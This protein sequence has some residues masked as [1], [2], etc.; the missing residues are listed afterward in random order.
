MWSEDLLI[1]IVF[2][3]ECD[4]FHC[5]NLNDAISFSNVHSTRDEDVKVDDARYFQQFC[6]LKALRKVLRMIKI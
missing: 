5:L 6:D 3:S 4:C 2:F 1:C